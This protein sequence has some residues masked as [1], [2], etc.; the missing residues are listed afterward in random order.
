M[1]SAETIS[2]GET[3]KTRALVL[4]KNGGQALDALHLVAAEAAAADRFLTCDDRLMRRYSG[5][6]VV[7]SPLIFITNLS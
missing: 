7:Q 1:L 3:I 2:L 6:M 4:E 5:Q